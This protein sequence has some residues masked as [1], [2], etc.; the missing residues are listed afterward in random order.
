[1]K[2]LRISIKYFIIM[3]IA[4]GIA[5]PLFITMIG[6]VAFNRQSNGSLVVDG[7]TVMGSELVGQNFL[8]P[9]YFWSRPSASNYEMVPSM[10]TNLGPTSSALAGMVKKRVGLTGLP[11]EMLFASASGLDPHIS[12]EAAFIQL[13]RVATERGLSG[14]KIDELRGMLYSFSEDR[15]FGVLGEP[16]VNVLKLNIELDKIFSKVK[17]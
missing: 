7:E 6:K 9:E 14:K 2:I 8:H 10:A 15:M 17:H 4:T 3:S 16:R 5:Y 11:K 12:P 13:P 1:M